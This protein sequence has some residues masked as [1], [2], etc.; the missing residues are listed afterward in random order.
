MA[1]ARSG[2]V[3]TRSA[4]GTRTERRRF[5][6][7]SGFRVDLRSP[8]PTPS[9]PSDDSCCPQSSIPSFRTALRRWRSAR[10]CSGLRAPP[11]RDAAPRCEERCE[12]AGAA[13]AGS[14]DSTARAQTA[15]Q[16]ERQRQAQPHPAETEPSEKAKQQPNPSEQ[17][18]NPPTRSPAANCSPKAAAPA[19]PSVGSHRA[20]ATCP[21]PAAPSRPAAREASPRP[22]PCRLPG[23][24]HL[25]ASAAPAP[26]SLS[27]FA[28]RRPRGAS[29]RGAARYLELGGAVPARLFQWQRTCRPP[30]PISARLGPLPRSFSERIR[31]R[32]ESYLRA[33][34]PAALRAAPHMRGGGGWGRTCAA[35]RCPGG[36]AGPGGHGKQNYL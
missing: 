27:P 30:R 18:P 26:P 28:R 16:R 7:F 24:R 23:G 36:G 35:L 22:R 3:P 6:F 31:R 19:G 25:S 33:P 32:S 17:T 11:P 21:R 5:P 12:G 10:G 4:G 2:E 8:F 15:Q 34:G 20:A 29:R 13:A 1:A 14:R 9:P